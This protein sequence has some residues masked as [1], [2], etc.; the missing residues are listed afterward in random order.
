VLYS[1]AYALVRLLLEVLIVRSRPN[2][3]LRAEVLALRHQLRV[4]ERQV[5]RPR[6]QPTDRLLLAAISG[7]RSCPDRPASAAG[8]DR[9]VGLAVL[10][11]R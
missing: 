10:P 2:P 1:F 8:S 9:L 5:A 6:G 7:V 3:E 4:R 11:P